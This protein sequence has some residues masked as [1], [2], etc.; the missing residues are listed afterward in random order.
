MVGAQRGSIL[1]SNLQLTKQ[2][3]VISETW[4]FCFIKSREAS[5]VRT[6]KQLFHQPGSR[7]GGAGEGGGEGDK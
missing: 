5:G 6:T 3:V 2:V 7:D 1:E 4:A